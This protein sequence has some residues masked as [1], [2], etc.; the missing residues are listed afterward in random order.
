M[1]TKQTGTKLNKINQIIS[2]F[3]VF[4]KVFKRANSS[5]PEFL[6][7]KFTLQKLKN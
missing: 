7:N 5:T 3:S 1:K 2:S 6:I 4:S